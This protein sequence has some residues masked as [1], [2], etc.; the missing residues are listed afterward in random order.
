VSENAIRSAAFAGDLIQLVR[1]PAVRG[2]GC[3]AFIFDVDFFHDTDPRTIHAVAV[4]LSA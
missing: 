1:L 2:R 3:R 4:T